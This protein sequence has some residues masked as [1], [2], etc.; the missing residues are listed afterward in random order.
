MNDK[1]T[2][3]PFVKG[4]WLCDDCRTLVAYDENHSVIDTIAE[5]FLHNSNSETA[6]ATINLLTYAPELYK[7]AKTV[8]EKDLDFDWREIQ[9]YAKQIIRDINNINT[10]KKDKTK[11]EILEDSLSPCKFCG[12]EADVF[13][14]EYNGGAQY[15]IHCTNPFCWVSSPM[16]GNFDDARN[17][18]NNG[19]L[20]E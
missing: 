4:F 20:P 5:F 15:I 6:R 8:T 19:I 3:Y 11:S 12:D 14:R 13:I 9:N 17:Y 2:P 10:G 7:L 18:W 1:N 16:F